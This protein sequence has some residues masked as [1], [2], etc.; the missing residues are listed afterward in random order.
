MFNKRMLK[1]SNL[2]EFSFF[3]FIKR[4]QQ[5]KF[6]TRSWFN[7]CKWYVDCTWERVEIFVNDNT[8]YSH[9]YTRLKMF[10]RNE[11]SFISCSLLVRG[12]QCTGLMLTGSFLPALYL[13]MK[14]K[15]MI[16]SIYHIKHNI[17]SKPKAYKTAMWNDNFTQVFFKVQ[18]A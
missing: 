14:G 11:K 2:W 6:I 3:F 15:K 7:S 18:I 13:W 9:V 1:I 12:S 5:M 4:I 16:S 8:Y 10:Y 17:K